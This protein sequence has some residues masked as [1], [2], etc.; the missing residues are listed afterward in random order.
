MAPADEFPSSATFAAEKE[1]RCNLAN[2]GKRKKR[3]EKTGRKQRNW[4]S[5]RTRRRACRRCRVFS[6]VEA[7]GDPRARMS[8]RAATVQRFLIL[9]NAHEKR[10]AEE[11]PNRKRTG[12][13]HAREFSVCVG[14]IF[15]P[16]FPRRIPEV[17][18][19]PSLA[20][21]RTRPVLSAR[22]YLCS[23]FGKRDASERSFPSNRADTIKY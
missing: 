13:R 1:N 22:A 10:A 16:V 17:S 2:G 6:F 23:S 19:N 7:R 3:R 20:P 11:E 12:R 4:Y 21:S 8:F 5:E 15:Q 18:F 9:V 14:Q